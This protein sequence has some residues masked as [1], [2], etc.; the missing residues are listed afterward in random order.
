[1]M[2]VPKSVTRVTKDGVKFIDNVDRT[3]YCIHELCRAALRDSAKFV[4]KE[5]KSSY[6]STFNKRTGNAGKS[7]A[8][9]VISAKKTLYPRVNIGIPKAYK[10][11][12]VPGFYSIFQEI[13]SSKQPRLGLLQNAVESNIPQI[14][15]IQSQY[16]SALENESQA[17]SLIDENEHVDYEDV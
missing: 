13:G 16:L 14:I 10:G 15:E 7:L 1:M 5:F 6:Y 11:K 12:E 17:L 4:K 9:E 2:S 8:S 3:N